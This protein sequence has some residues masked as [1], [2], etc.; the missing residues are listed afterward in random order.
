MA[1]ANAASWGTLPNTLTNLTD[2][3]G[4]W[5]ITVPKA[6][7]GQLFYRA[8]ATNVCM[9]SMATRAGLYIR[10]EAQTN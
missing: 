8:K 3:N 4:L 1:V 9:D 10:E 6:T 7:S 5:S 2:P